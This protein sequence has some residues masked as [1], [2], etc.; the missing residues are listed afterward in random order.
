[1]PTSI[2]GCIVNSIFMRADKHIAGGFT[3]G[4]REFPLID[5]KF[6]LTKIVENI[7]YSIILMDIY[8]LYIYIILER[9]ETLF[10]QYWQFHA[11][12]IFS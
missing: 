9:I 12:A 6:C 7:F 3:F 1:M 2:N 10:F 4:G 11:F 5:I 8:M